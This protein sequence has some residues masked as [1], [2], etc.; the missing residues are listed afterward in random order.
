MK[1]L[2]LICILISMPLIATDSK[3][4]A[5]AQKEA[6][7]FALTQ[8][9]LKAHR[10]AAT[11]N[12]DKFFWNRTKQPMIDGVILH[13]QDVTD[14]TT[15]IRYTKLVT[16]LA[17]AP[18]DLEMIRLPNEPLTLKTLLIK[19][20][21]NKR[22]DAQQSVVP[23]DENTKVSLVSTQ[24]STQFNKTYGTKDPVILL[25]ET[26]VSKKDEDLLLNGTLGQQFLVSVLGYVWQAH[27]GPALMNAVGLRPLTPFEQIL[28]VVDSLV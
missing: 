11:D 19:A 1:R 3:T 4:E 12:N 20:Y 7:K 2:L 9:L 28:N 10:K 6:K 27:A 17:G 23:L 21:Q 8:L 13:K 5:D 24:E 16:L 14:V 15:K 26:Y 25:C 18:R 22:K